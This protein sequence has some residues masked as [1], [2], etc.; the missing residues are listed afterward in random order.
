MS[1]REIMQKRLNVIW[2]DM[3]V[4]VQSIIEENI[5][6]NELKENLNKIY[7]QESFKLIEEL[8]EDVD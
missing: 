4:D 7:K 1:R 6:R 3:I 8:R 5:M 2:M